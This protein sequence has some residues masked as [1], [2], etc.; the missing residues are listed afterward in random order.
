M[1]WGW[2]GGRGGGCGWVG[3][4]VNLYL[5]IGLEVVNNME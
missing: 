4:F 1:G 5:N 2:F 3:G